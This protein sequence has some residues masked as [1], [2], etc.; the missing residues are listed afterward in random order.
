MARGGYEPD[1]QRALIAL[2]ATVVGLAVIGVLYWARSIFIPLALA[3]FLAFVLSPAVAWVQRRGLGRTPAV[4]VVVAFAILLVGGIGAGVAQ[5]MAALSNTLPDRRDQIL[6]KITTLKQWIAG[7]GESRL[8]DLVTDVLD[9][10]NPKEKPTAGQAPTP[11]VVESG[12]SPLMSRLEAAAT[13]A[14]E[15][16]GTAAFAFILTVYVLLRKED[17]RNRMIRLLGHGKVTTTT[18]AV[19]DASK[20]ISR[21]LLTQLVLNGA[22]GVVIAVGLLLI[23]LKYALLWAFV[24][25]LMRY[26]PYVGTWI[27][28]LPPTLY[29]LAVSEGP[30]WYW[31]PVLVLA[32]FGGLELICNNIFEP[33]L[34]GPSMGLSEVA[35]L[36]AAAVWAFLWGPIGLI[37]SGPLTVCLLVLGKYVTRF[38][39]LE[40]LLGDEPAL[41]P[42]VAFYQRLAAHDHDEAATIALGELEKEGATPEAVFD[43]VIVPALCLARRDHEDGD[44]SADDLRF[45]LRTAR[46]VG[47]EVA[48]ARRVVVD[49]RESVAEEDRVR[50]LLCPAR[51]EVDHVGVDLLSHLLEPERWEI[52]VAADEILA[53]ELLIR[54]E[55]FRPAAVVI[56]AAPPGGLAHTRYLVAR[57]R[58]R[59]PDLRVVV[60][61]WGRSEEFADPEQAAFPG[62]DWVDDTLGETHKKLTEHHPVFAAGKTAVVGTTG[63]PPR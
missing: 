19:D 60:G 27:G 28:L 24:A 34:Y 42:R 16:L 32:L 9:V 1:W 5:Q 54:V 21:F 44:L 48:A 29:A 46:E 47:E 2:S 20:R 40:V 26:V 12:T 52:E 15:V 41:E 11:V 8:G 61:R 57:I 55:E 3:V 39:Y 17:L 58:S 18:K 36:L 43:R 50:L 45:V 30:H 33:M 56:G 14:I 4:L 7:N 63:A 59:F 38:K 10:V 62:A 25:F 49:A 6:Q 22:F 13:P 53:S 37:L 35:Q 23:G 51:D 31:Q